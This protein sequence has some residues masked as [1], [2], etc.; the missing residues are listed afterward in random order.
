MHFAYIS[1]VF[2]DLML[3]LPT[4][5][6]VQY[7]VLKHKETQGRYCL[8]FKMPMEGRRIYGVFNVKR[9][10]T[11]PSGL[12]ILMNL[13]AKSIEVGKKILLR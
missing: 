2:V 13:N 12:L 11:S 10:T 3:Q 9:A 4:L 7:S 6:D 5:M 8:P 1:K